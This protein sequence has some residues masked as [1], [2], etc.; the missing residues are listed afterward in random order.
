M[1]VTFDPIHVATIGVGLF[2]IAIGVATYSY[3]GR[4]LDHAREAQ[5]VVIEVRNESATPKGRTHPV[6]KF[7]TAEGAEIVV[8]SDEHHNV[9]PADTLPVIYDARNPHAIEITTLERARKRR[10]VFS[11]LGGALGLFVCGMG[12][13]QLL[14]RPE[15]ESDEAGGRSR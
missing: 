12:L 13:R 1:R 6:V 15:S 9:R 14:F 7:K 3:M 11:G 5:A 10:W 2:F 4:F 8:A